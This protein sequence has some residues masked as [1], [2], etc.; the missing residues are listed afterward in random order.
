MPYEW[1]FSYI[2]AAKRIVKFDKYENSK[3]VLKYNG[4]VIFRGHDK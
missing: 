1:H 3:I 4:G 2:C